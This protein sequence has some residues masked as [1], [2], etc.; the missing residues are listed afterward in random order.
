MKLYKLDEEYYINLDNINFIRL[1]SE[2]SAMKS[3][4][5]FIGG[6]F[7]LC[8]EEEADRIVNKLMIGGK[9]E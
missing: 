5:H 9:N 2:T 4:I 6:G 1:Y 8:E 3:E 7:I